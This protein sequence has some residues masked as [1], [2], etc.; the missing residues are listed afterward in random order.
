RAHA[1]V[2]APGLYPYQWC[3]DTGPIAL[4][5]AALGDFE[6]AWAE[7]RSLLSAQWPS[8]FVPHIVF[9]EPN[10]EYFP[11]PDVWATAGH[12]PPTTGITQPPL[13]VSAATAVFAA[14]PDRVRAGRELRALLPQLVA[15]VE[16]LCRARR[17]PHG[18]V[19]A[20]H[21]WETGMDN[22]PAWDEP[23][24]ATPTETH[25]HLDRRDTKTVA[26]AQRPTTEEYR[27]YLGI[28]AALRD[29]GWDTERQVDVSPFAVEDP[30]F[31]A[32][33]ARAAAD[34]AAAARELGDTPRAAALEARA[35]ELRL[36]LEALWDDEQR[37]YRAFDARAGRAVGPA[38]AGG[39]IALW[40]GCRAD[41]AAVL[42]AR[43]RAWA[44]PPGVGVATSDPN[45]PGFDPVRYWRGPVWVLVNWLVAEGA[46]VAGDDALAE[47]LRAM[48]RELVAH[49]GLSEYYDPRDGTGIGGTGFS[50]SAALTL[51]WIVP[52]ARSQA[53]RSSSPGS[54]GVTTFEDGPAAK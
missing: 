4:G 14:D 53:P 20:V 35:G 54:L 44:R 41:R 38:T 47:Q 50:W 23:L 16:W 40:A 12:S 39:L 13:P 29:D 11:G 28:V 24:A 17:G 33:A 46:R 48:T 8:G 34:L 32:I 49:E 43:A 26:A 37:S 30:G 15:W 27:H 1:T 21:P 42:A 25:R 2:P 31:S 10:D 19:V 7:L 5:W 51:W 18:A 6:Q 36:G 9:W 52:D 22:S 3:W 45:A